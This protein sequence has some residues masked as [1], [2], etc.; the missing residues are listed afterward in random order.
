MSRIRNAAAVCLFV[1]IVLSAAGCRKAP[2]SAKQSGPAASGTPAAK[3]ATNPARATPKP[4]WE[5]KTALNL[6][7][8]QAPEGA[9][10][11]YSFDMASHGDLT[12]L[13]AVFA[14]RSDTEIKHLIDGAAAVSKGEAQIAGCAAALHEGKDPAWGP[15]KIWVLKEPHPTSG[16]AVALVVAGHKQAAF[17]EDLDKILASLK[18]APVQSTRDP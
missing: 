4:Q 2:D 13:D 12:A 7:T 14:V 11:S 6:V 1:L 10:W 5:T 16:K 18:V 8:F 15:M 3:P 17:Q 9:G